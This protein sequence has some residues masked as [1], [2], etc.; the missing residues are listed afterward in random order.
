VGAELTIDKPVDETMVAEISSLPDELYRNR[1][2]T[3]AY[4]DLACQ[5]A[6][7]THSRGTANWCTFARWASYTVGE[8]LELEAPTPR[9]REF[10]AHYHPMLGPLTGPI[11]QGQVWYRTRND[12][13]FP[14][15]L[16]IANR[17]VF[18]EMGRVLTGFIAWSRKFDQ[19][20]EGAWANYAPTIAT[21]R[22]TDSFPASDIGQ[23]RRGLECYHRARFADQDAK[24]ELLY[25]GNVLLVAYEQWRLRIMLQ[26]ALDPAA[27]HLVKLRSGQGGAHPDNLAFAKM[28]RTRRGWEYRHSSDML[29]W[30]VGQGSA[31]ATKY[32]MTIDAPIGQENPWSLSLGLG[33]DKGFKTDPK[34]PLPFAEELAT[35]DD[36]EIDA[37]YHHFDLSAGVAA[38]CRA[39][40]WGN[41]PDRMNVLVNLF[42]MEHSDEYLHQEPRDDDKVGLHQCAGLHLDLRDEHLDALR[43][44]GDDVLD[45]AV[46]KCATD[47]PDA[48]TFLRHLVS[49][50]PSEIDH[51]YGGPSELPAWASKAKIR[52]GQQFFQ[53]YGIEIALALFGGAL[54]ETYTGAHGAQVLITTTE[55]ISNPR[56]RVAETGQMLVDITKIE[57][58]KAPLSPGTRGYQAARGVRLFHAAVRHMLLTD[59][60][61]NW[62]VG[63]LGIPINQEDLLGALT[64][65]SITV[66]C[67]LNALGVSFTRE[68]RDAYI[69]L[70]LVVGALMG[71]DY[72]QI[73]TGRKPDEQPFSYYDLELM[74]TTIARRQ[75]A[76]SPGGQQLTAAL[77]NMQRQSL[78][79]FLQGMLRGLPHD[80][81]RA[82]I[83]D[84][85][86]DM[87]GVPPAGVL[88]L[89]L[90][91]GRPAMRFLTRHFPPAAPTALLTRRLYKH[92]IESS[93]PHR[94]QPAVE[95][96]G[97]RPPWRFPKRFGG[98]D[99]SDED[100]D[101]P[102][103]A[104]AG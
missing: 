35:L 26:L 14:T 75:T 78:P 59:P 88:R 49:K 63:A 17:L 74:Q 33:L 9:L 29:Q 64:G 11:A 56:R 66:I 36:P 69:H 16:G 73:V 80:Q 71:I 44:K 48:R 20:D 21:D 51:L 82:L 104:P 47:W 32:V 31:L 98:R 37:L 40:D 3:W 99:E 18:S 86:A 67:C 95:P 91:A 57:R 77:L 79:G 1:W 100:G 52:Q 50:G 54:P 70:W 68:E 85:M 27:D 5:I 42:R 92:W 10:F 93:V 7:L 24:V 90:E 4:Y 53:D 8:N 25:A 45:E 97:E 43:H 89:V 55:M 60:R 41:F 13:A 87:L 30:F 83:G 6:E 103:G 38:N 23:L 19:F 102:A 61:V 94:G 81:M 62:D 2:I 39:D 34:K 46:A 28:R 76:P 12:R 72:S 22:A 58:G 84:P 65:F 15:T 96:R 101:L